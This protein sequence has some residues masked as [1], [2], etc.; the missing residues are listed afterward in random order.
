MT[1]AQ[2]NILSHRYVALEIDGAPHGVYLLIENVLAS[3]SRMVPQAAA[4]VQVATAYVSHSQM[5][6]RYAAMGGW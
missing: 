1:R 3:V 2:I 4:V 6:D 5:I